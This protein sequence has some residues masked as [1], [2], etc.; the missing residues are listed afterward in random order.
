MSLVCRFFQKELKTRLPSERIGLSQF[1]FGGIHLCQVS[2]LV[3]A[4][5]PVVGKAFIRHA[6]GFKAACNKS[7]PSILESSVWTV[8]RHGR[9]E[10]WSASLSASPFSALFLPLFSA[11]RA[12]ACHK[13]IYSTGKTFMSSSVWQ[14]AT[15]RMSSIA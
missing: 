7:V 4:C 9:Q 12:S 2:E 5:V 11:L 15:K 8:P 13:G 1:V 14:F 3:S 10:K 6:D